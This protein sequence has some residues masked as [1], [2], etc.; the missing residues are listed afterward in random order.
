MKN[1]VK[2]KVDICHSQDA[3]NK[4]HV[5][6]IFMSSSVSVAKRPRIFIL[7]LYKCEIRNQHKYLLIVWKLV[8]IT[9]INAFLVPPSL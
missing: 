1:K 9:I 8:S 3:C 2:N 5:N 7:E 6:I 4:S